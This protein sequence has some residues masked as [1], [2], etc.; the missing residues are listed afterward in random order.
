MNPGNMNGMNGMDGMSGMSGMNGMPMTNYN[1]MNAM[2]AMNSLGQMNGQMNGQVNGQ[3]GG[4]VGNQMM[5]MGLQRPIPAQ[6]AAMQ[7]QKREFNG[8]AIQQDILRRVHSMDKS[9]FPP[10]WQRTVN[11]TIRVKNICE[12]IAALRIISR[13]SQ[14]IE[15]LSNMAINFE[16]QIF[17]KSADQVSSHCL[18]FDKASANL[19]TGEL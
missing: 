5:G 2:N 8:Q 7:Q 13:P 9:T 3:M 16:T 12:M 6:I 17:V 4:G 14:S 18:V 1:Q 19:V 11:Q 10:G 15:A